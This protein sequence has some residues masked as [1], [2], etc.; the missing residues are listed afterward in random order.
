M[1]QPGIS[2]YP[3]AF[4]D[5]VVKE[6]NDAFDQLGVSISRAANQT[7]AQHG[8]SRTTVIDWAKRRGAMPAPTWGMVY[9]KD[10]EILLLRQQIA[11]LERTVA[12]L[13][14]QLPSP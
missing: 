4:K 6:F 1:N 8:I 14:A 11:D 5:Q 7:A 13:Q 12:E 3:E 10:D 2:P 9:A